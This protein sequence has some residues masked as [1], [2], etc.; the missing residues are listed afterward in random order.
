M[1]D[2][3]VNKHSVVTIY[4][5]YTLYAEAQFCLSACCMYPLG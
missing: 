2:T 3:R 1:N 4:V 5:T